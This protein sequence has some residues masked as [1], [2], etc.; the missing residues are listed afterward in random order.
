MDSIFIDEYVWSYRDF[1]GSA[2]KNVGTPPQKQQLGKSF[3]TSTYICPTCNE[4]L[5]KSNAQGRVQIRTPQE[6]PYTLQSVFLC[7]KC[8]YLFSEAQPRITLKSG[9]VWFLNQEEIV[10]K[11]WRHIDSVAAEILSPLPPYS[12]VCEKYH[13]ETQFTPEEMATLAQAHQQ[14]GNNDEAVR[15][16][17]NAADLGHPGAQYNL[18]CLYYN[19]QIIQ[20]S[21]K[22]AAYR[23]YQ[24]ACHGYAPAQDSL[25]YMY[26]NGRGVAENRDAAIE[27]WEIA[28]DQGYAQ[29]QYELGWRHAQVGNTQVAVNM[30]KKAAVQGHAQAQA[31]LEELCK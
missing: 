20:Q 22:H 2:F 25:A 15:W 30:L 28:A 6:E 7:P 17:I 5:L 29:A 3:Y 9:V 16:Y 8:H 26:W 13:H 18:G 1:G 4:L 19:G 27:L 10:E 31:L 24:A 21:D 23:F 11:V 12:G 14:R